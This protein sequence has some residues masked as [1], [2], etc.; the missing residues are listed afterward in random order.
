MKPATRTSLILDKLPAIATMETTHK[1]NFQYVRNTIAFKNIIFGE[2]IGSLSVTECLLSN[3]SYARIT[4]QTTLVL[5]RVNYLYTREVQP[6]H[7]G[8]RASRVVHHNDFKVLMA[9]SFAGRQ[10]VFLA[11]QLSPAGGGQSLPPAV[12]LVRRVMS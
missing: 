1:S 10:G 12:W 5:V 3:N 11:R 2:S 7:S 9:Y 6:I 4:C 8:K